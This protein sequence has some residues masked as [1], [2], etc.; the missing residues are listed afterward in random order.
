[1]ERTEE[2]RPLGKRK[3]RLESNT[4]MELSE[5]RRGVDCTDVGQ[6]RNR[7]RAFVSV[8]INLPVL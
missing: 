6:G 2:R 4:K 3:S 8:E 7:R 1:M 5:V